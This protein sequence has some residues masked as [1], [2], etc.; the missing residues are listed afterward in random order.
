MLYMQE[1]I[2]DCLRFGVPYI[3]IINP[4]LHKGYVA[5][6]ASMVE[7]ESGI[8]ATSDPDIQVSVAEILDID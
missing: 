5:T 4:R 1:K 6:K 7:A 3:W 8:L 2:D